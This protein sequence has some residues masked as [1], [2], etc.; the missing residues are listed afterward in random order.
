[1]IRLEPMDDAGFREFLERIVPARAERWVRRGLWT[2]D[3]GLA[4]SRQEYASLFSQGRSTP[5]H[6]F[7]N[8]VESTRGK[9]VGEAW[10]HAREAGGKVQF[11]IQWIRIWP[12]H[13]RRGYATDVLRLL[14]A[15]ARGMG[16]ESL[17]L[18]VWADNPGALA[19]YRKV[20]FEVARMD[21][22]KPVAPA[23]EPSA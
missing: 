21:L 13:R 23:G 5:G 20:G 9:I 7:A 1:M 11:W 18:S 8:V 15:T 4:T 19:L 16:A 14:E 6:Y 10:Y 17:R 2:A 22:V 12:E 3:R